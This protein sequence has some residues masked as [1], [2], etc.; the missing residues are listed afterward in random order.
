MNEYS[1]LR[2]I[3]DPSVVEGFFTFLDQADQFE[4][5]KEYRDQVQK[6]D[7]ELLKNAITLYKQGTLT[8]DQFI[9]ICDQL[10]S[11]NQ[12]SQDDLVSEIKHRLG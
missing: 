6:S 12:V 3:F 9:T 4:R 2:L 8:K 11:S 5:T 1:I 10:V 7:Q